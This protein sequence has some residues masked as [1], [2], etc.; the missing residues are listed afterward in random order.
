MERTP[1]G[2]PVGVDDPYDHADRCDHLTS[3]GHCR[4]AREYADRD[5]AFARERA[6][7]DYECVAAADGCEFRDCPHYASTT[8]GR[9]CTRCGLEEV[10]MA[11][12]SAARPLLEE[13]HLSYGTRDGDDPSHEI[14]VALCRWCHTKVHKSFARIDDDAAPDPE[15]IAAREARRTKELEEMG[16]QSARDRAG[17]R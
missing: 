16:F 2:T 3:D 8:N 13:H 4:L 17:D 12:D 5:P 9:E 10:R 7:A 11:H 15:A 14:T 6:R 1:T